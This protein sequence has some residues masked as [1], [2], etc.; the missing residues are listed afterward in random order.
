MRDPN[1]IRTIGE[2]EMTPEW[3]KRAESA[4]SPLEF[5][6]AEERASYHEQG[7]LIALENEGNH[8]GRLLA[9]IDPTD[10]FEKNRKEIARLVRASLYP[11]ARYT[12]YDL[13][14][15]AGGRGR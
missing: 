8:K 7:K 9:V 3:R 11:D 6:S 14:G 10:D 4:R 5:L 15:M 13:L 1:R 12:I 2:E